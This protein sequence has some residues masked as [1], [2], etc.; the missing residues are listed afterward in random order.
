MPAEEVRHLLNVAA[1]IKLEDIP[2]QP[3][4]RGFHN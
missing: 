2:L 3:W 4:A 1:D